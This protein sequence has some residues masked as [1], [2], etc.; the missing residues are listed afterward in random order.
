[1]LSERRAAG[2]A[3]VLRYAPG[4]VY[5][6][7]SQV[8]E[9]LQ[10]K[11]VRIAASTH[12]SVPNAANTV[13]V[14]VAEV[15]DHERPMPMGPMWKTNFI[16]KTRT[17]EEA[18]LENAI[19]NAL[20]SHNL[21]LTKNATIDIIEADAST[22]R[23]SLSIWRDRVGFV[24]SD[25]RDLY[26]V[27]V[28]AG[29]LLAAVTAAVGGQVPS[30]PVTADVRDEDLSFYDK[31]V[32]GCVRDEYLAMLRALPGAHT[33]MA[34]AADGGSIPCGEAMLLQG[35]LMMLYAESDAV[36]V[37]I[38]AQLIAS[39]NTAATATLVFSAPSESLLY[40]AARTVPLTVVRRV[41]RFHTTAP[42][43]HVKWANVYAFNCGVNI[44]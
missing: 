32:V 4:K 16:R 38:L 7:I 14:K 40:K 20:G 3:C 18:V 5:C 37:A 22:L 26:E 41:H 10:G 13:A 12:A 35:T 17:P 6:S 11:P 42:P 36:A 30:Y 21:E 34:H 24:V 25:P 15:R 1:M 31:R 9:D 44:A 23:K 8:A 27:S 43:Q 28:P 2:F 29:A 33:R 19:V 39:T